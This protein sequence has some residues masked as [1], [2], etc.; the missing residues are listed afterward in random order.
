M[1]CLP[2]EARLRLSKTEI[3]TSRLIGNTCT[4]CLVRGLIKVPDNDSRHNKL[5]SV[6][7]NFRPY[8]LPHP[9][10]VNDYFGHIKNTFPQVTSTQVSVP[11]HYIYIELL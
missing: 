3:I 6:K 7:L 11:C 5:C 2:G 9:L 10:F 1:D 8:M 4:Y